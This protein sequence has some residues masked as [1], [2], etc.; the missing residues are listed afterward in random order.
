MPIK[1]K[2]FEDKSISSYIHLK[3]LHRN[4]SDQTIFL[5]FLYN[6][7]S[8]RLNVLF[9]NFDAFSEFGDIYWKRRGDH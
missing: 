6:I 8:K 9:V 1:D 2:I 3:Q 7:I 5:Q 4:Y